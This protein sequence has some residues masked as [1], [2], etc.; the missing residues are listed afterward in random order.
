MKAPRSHLNTY[1]T[2]RLQVDEVQEVIPFVSGGATK[3]DARRGWMLQAREWLIN[4]PIMRLAQ[5]GIVKRGGIDI[6][7]S[8][9]LA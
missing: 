7:A 8:E 4:L 2:R 9:P 5:F 6:N 1:H 3:D